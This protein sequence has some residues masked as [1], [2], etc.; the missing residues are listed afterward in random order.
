MAK[1][2]KKWDERYANGRKFVLTGLRVRKNNS[3]NEKFV[4]LEFGKNEKT[5]ISRHL[6]DRYLVPVD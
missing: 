2:E 5:I 3:G 1:D 6:A 4:L